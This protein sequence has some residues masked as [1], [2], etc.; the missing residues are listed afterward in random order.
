MVLSSNATVI[1]VNLS[2]NKYNLMV[3]DYDLVI[4]KLM[5]VYMCAGAALS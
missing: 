4:L 3:D 2:L 5:D 1:F